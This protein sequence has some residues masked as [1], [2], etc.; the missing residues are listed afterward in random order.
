[1]TSH[2]GPVSRLNKH[3]VMSAIALV[4]WNGQR[5]YSHRLF[6]RS[7]S[8]YQKGLSAIKYWLSSAFPVNAVPYDLQTS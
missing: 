1:M 5:M 3:F 2:S 6:H 7:D 8:L 4:D